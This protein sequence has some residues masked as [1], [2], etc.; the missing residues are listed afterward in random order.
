MRRT[1][2]DG[3][4]EKIGDEVALEME[5]KKQKR[6]AGAQARKVLS[7]SKYAQDRRLYSGHQ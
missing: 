2:I 1:P 4:F 3:D 5:A 7:D 6:L